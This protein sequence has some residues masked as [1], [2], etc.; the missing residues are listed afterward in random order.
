M[1]HG[2]L[3]LTDLPKVGV[4]TRKKSGM[5][6]PRRLLELSDFLTPPSSKGNS[7]APRPASTDGLAFS[8]VLQ[9]LQRRSRMTSYCLSRWCIGDQLK[10]HVLS[11]TQVGGL[12][13][14]EKSFHVVRA[15]V[16]QCV[17]LVSSGQRTEGR[18]LFRRYLCPSRKKRKRQKKR[19]RRRK[20]ES[21][22][23][24]D[25]STT[26]PASAGFMV[27]NASCFTLRR[28]T[29]AVTKMIPTRK[30]QPRRLHERNT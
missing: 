8:A 4:L 5:A 29:R 30:T 21:E 19:A 28:Q 10:I 20:R 25:P 2:L 17:C 11:T 12:S 26:P 6:V 23:E 14:T 15:S 7:S 3:Q 1:L 27:C 13:F 22:K 18:S 24:R 9:N 16:A